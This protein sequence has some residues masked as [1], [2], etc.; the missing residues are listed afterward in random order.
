[1]KSVSDIFLLDKSK[2][3]NL[4]GFGDKSAENLILSIENS[5]KISFSKF[6]YGLG[7]KNVGEHISKLFEV[8]FLSDLNKFMNSTIEELESIDGVGPLVAK[9]VIEFWSKEANKTIV[10]EC[11]N[12]G[13][14]LKKKEVLKDQFLANKTFVFTGTLKTITRNNG[15]DIVSKYGGSTTNS[16]SKKTDFLVSGSSAG[17]KL[18]KAKDLNI[19][20]LNEKE[21]LEIVNINEENKNS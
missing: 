19:K 12:R 14:I 16:I 4:E 13:L 9:E 6:I 7:I 5:K 8:Y 18:R 21:F 3:K 10:N 11:L 15:K 20:I 1:M 17:S 2:L